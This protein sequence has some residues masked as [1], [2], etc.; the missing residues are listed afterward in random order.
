MEI[1]RINIYRKGI[2]EVDKVNREHL[3]DNGLM[4]GIDGEQDRISEP[5]ALDEIKKICN[6]SLYL[7]EKDIN[8]LV[9]ILQRDN[10]I[11]RKLSIEQVRELNALI[12]DFFINESLGRAEIKALVD[13]FRR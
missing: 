4:K 7:T 5:V 8:E 2:G 1:K 12:V 13:S 9:E 11:I 6:R 3:S 10:P